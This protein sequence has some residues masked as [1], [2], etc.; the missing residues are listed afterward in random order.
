MQRLRT[1]LFAMLL[2]IVFVAC[3][4]EQGT[5]FTNDPGDSSGDADPVADTDDNATADDDTDIEETPAPADEDEIE[6]PDTDDD[7]IEEQAEETPEEDDL[8]RDP[9]DPNP[10]TGEYMT[11]ECVILPNDMYECVCENGYANVGGVCEDI[12][13]CIP[14]PCVQANQNVCVELEDGIECRCN[15]GYEFNDADEC[16][17]A[18][19]N[20]YHGPG[21]VRVEFID[22]SDTIRLEGLP[23]TD[24]YG[25]QGVSVEPIV[26][27]GQARFPT[28]GLYFYNFIGHDGTN[29]LELMGGDLEDLP[30]SDNLPL[31]VLYWNDEEN[32]LRLGS[33][34]IIG[35]PSEF[36]ELKMNGGRIVVLR[37]V[38]E[39]CY[40][41]ERECAGEG[42]LV[43]EC[44]DGQWMIVEACEN[45]ICDDGHCLQCRSGEVACYENLLLSCSEGDWTVETDCMPEGKVCDVT[46]PGCRACIGGSRRC[47]GN[48]PQIC[49]QGGWV[50]LSACETDEICENGLCIEGEPLDGLW[51][52]TGQ[53]VAVDD[54]CEVPEV[55]MEIIDTVTL[56]QTGDSFTLTTRDET[57]PL[58]IL[59]GHVRETSLVADDTFDWSAP[60]EDDRN[61]GSEV[62]SVV[63]IT[64][65]NTVDFN[66]QWRNSRLTGSWTL[67]FGEY[68]GDCENSTGWG[69]LPQPAPCTVKIEFDLVAYSC[70]PNG[71]E[72]CYDEQDNDCDGYLD[73]NDPEGCEIPCGDFGEIRCIDGSP[74][75]CQE[76]YRWTQVEACSD[77]E[78]CDPDELACVTRCDQEQTRCNGNMQEVCNEQTGL[79]QSFSNCADDDMVCLDGTCRDLEDSCTSEFEGERQCDG[80]RA[81]I[82]CRSGQWDTVQECALGTFCQ[83]AECRMYSCDEGETACDGDRLMVC[84]ENGQWNLMQ[85][86]IQFDAVCHDD[87]CVQP[88]TPDQTF[89]Y[90][91]YVLVC[92]EDGFFWDIQ[93]D[94]AE[95]GQLCID[96]ACTSVSET[97]E[98]EGRT[99]CLGHTSVECQ[100]DGSWQVVENCEEQG[101]DCLNGR[102]RL[103]QAECSPAWSEC[104][105]AW[106]DESQQDLPL[107]SYCDENAQWTQSF[108]D[109]DQVCDILRGGCVEPCEESG[110][111]RFCNEYGYVL[112]CNPETGL[113]EVRDA[114]WEYP[115]IC[116]DGTC[117]SLENSCDVPAS[118]P[119]CIGSYVVI[120]NENG[121]WQGVEEC[122]EGFCIDG[123]CA[124]PPWFACEPG[125]IRCRYDRLEICV[126]TNWEFWQECAEGSQCGGEPDCADPDM[127]CEVEGES[128]CI[129]EHP[130]LCLEGEWRLKDLCDEN[131]SCLHGDCAETCE[132]YENGNS[133][134]TLE[135]GL[136]RIESCINDVWQTS[137]ICAASCVENDNTAQCLDTCPEGETTC[138]GDRLYRCDGQGEW[139]EIQ[140]CYAAGGSCGF[141]EDEARCVACDEDPQEGQCRGDVVV[142]CLDG[143]W[144]GVETCPE[145]SCQYGSCQPTIF[146]DWMNAYLIW[147]VS[148]E[149]DGTT[150]EFPPEGWP[151]TLPW[152]VVPISVYDGTWYLNEISDEYDRYPIAIDE[153]LVEGRHFTG[154]GQREIGGEGCRIQALTTFD[155]MASEDFSTL[156]GTLTLEF[157]EFEGPHC[158]MAMHEIPDFPRPENCTWTLDFMGE[159]R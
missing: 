62:H 1:L 118:E 10:C 159:K 72:L 152:V 123:D 111:E 135:N 16:V 120:C 92:S 86:C 89:C 73:E 60:G 51:R 54:T 49:S 68:E 19:A 124:S 45:A 142:R 154:T 145:R 40:D 91:T 126:G 122:E 96:Q 132:Y 57:D 34:E 155:A 41:G 106:D 44:Q 158:A 63:E 27:R 149:A 97:C 139:Q 18:Q 100:A 129:G 93:E 107:Y 20:V 59:E 7:A 24:V 119:Q 105:M 28:E 79:Y 121:Q 153:G 4:T 61:C 136:W 46:I 30:Y 109:A 35:L 114:C 117:L 12:N 66:G 67:E 15:P 94:C 150:C 3:D 141:L 98:N 116:V 127:S 77:N 39:V 157:T 32:E 88:C 131:Q 65:E 80:D 70:I 29:L 144:T 112:S 38:A 58:K 134:C 13:P 101:L 115:A 26:R 138:L 87:T 90:N 156:E 108:C 148:S 56:E 140:D 71:E 84:D 17:R 137:D 14:N 31:L 36:G 113:L 74:K 64:P 102:C 104:E 151:I 47:D 69:D 75:I 53:T 110:D 43:R 130:F 25:Y 146:P 125:N 22:A 50:D 133:Y 33:E 48:Q 143:V 99:R 83:Q 95:S 52:M 23:R 147:G 82:E 9:C 103:P 76:N 81:V 11:G 8:N 128:T 37:R 55:G 21:E 5:I 6:L 2:T 85:D 42:T 78:V